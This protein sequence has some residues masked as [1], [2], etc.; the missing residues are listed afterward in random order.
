MICALAI[1]AARSDRLCVPRGGSDFLRSR[2][3][4]ASYCDSALGSLA[5]HR[6]GREHRHV[7]DRRA[8]RPSLAR[9]PNDT[10]TAGSTRATAVVRAELD[11]A[12]PVY[13]LTVFAAVPSM[14]DV[15]V[16]NGGPLTRC[17]GCPA[18]ISKK[19]LAAATAEAATE[20]RV[21][22]LRD[23]RRQR[24]LQIG[25]GRGR[26]APIKNW[27]DA[28]RSRVVSRTATRFRS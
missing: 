25:R 2:V 6:H 17:G 14:S 18:S 11:P 10:V 1:S 7:L 19:S 27:F 4:N 22:E 28:R 16:P 3:V 21:R 26:V 23:R 13:Q 8:K 24:G 9:I 20:R 15:A 5:E 12:S